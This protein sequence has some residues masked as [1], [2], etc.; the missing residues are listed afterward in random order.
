MIQN[1]AKQNTVKQNSMKNINSNTNRQI[2]SLIGQLTLDEKI[3]MI[4]GS[5]LFRTGAV[6]RLGIPALVFS[7]GPMGVRQDF[8]PDG[9]TSADGSKSRQA[10]C[11][12]AAL[13]PQPGIPTLSKWPD[14]C[15][16][17]RLGQEERT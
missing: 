14:S 2:E 5:E 7:D 4:H 8:R 10:T 12:A 3:A 1:S 6:P 15:S 13:W 17:K 9:W 11:P 16:A